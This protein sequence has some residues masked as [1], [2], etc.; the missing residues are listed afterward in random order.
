MF[1]NVPL[2]PSSLLILTPSPSVL[3]C[4]TSPTCIHHYLRCLGALSHFTG[5]THSQPSY[6]FACSFDV[7]RGF[8]SELSLSAFLRANPSPSAHHHG[9]KRSQSGNDIFLATAMVQPG[10]DPRKITDQW[11][12]LVLLLLRAFRS[13]S[14]LNSSLGRT[15]QQMDKESLGFR[16]LLDP[17][18][19]SLLLSTHL[20]C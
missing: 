2:T 1:T 6:V 3:V 11:Y 5:G 8:G 9:H 13:W 17:R 7:S 12:P 14:K 19:T 20:S 15:G 4:T 16:L 18:G 10:F